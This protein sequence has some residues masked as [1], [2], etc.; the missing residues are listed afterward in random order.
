MRS[1]TLASVFI[2]ICATPWAQSYTIIDS[3]RLPAQ[4]YVGDPVELRYRIRSDERLVAPAELPDPAWGT[5]EALTIGHSDGTYDLRIVVVPFEPGTL[6]LPSL[7]LGG[8]EIEGFSLVVASVLEVDSS[9]QPIF[10][11]QRLPGTRAALILFSVLIFGTLAVALYLFG[12]GRA[13]LR[14]LIARYRAR[15]PYRRLRKDLT[16]LEAQAEQM[17]AREFYILLV[18]A[19][20][21][22]LSSVLRVD[23]RSATTSE[24]LRY[25]PAL[26][27][28][29]AAPPSEVD[30]LEPILHRAD[31]VKFAGRDE[32]SLQR[33]CDV[34]R[35]VTL[36]EKL[37]S[38]RR[39][40]RAH[41][42]KREAE[43]ARI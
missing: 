11:P 16:L 22:Y 10:G 8:A 36:F 1:L 24:L 13:H 26:A 37:E 12:P 41:P 38:G 29:C 27:S 2:L 14:M 5:I 3:V 40:L 35:C 9:L 39:R 30:S 25:L 21:R 17:A 18:Q 33:S 23:C 19:M 20:Q 6:T 7:P 34:E 28:L 32:P 42:R 4:S 15:L 31:A 43:H